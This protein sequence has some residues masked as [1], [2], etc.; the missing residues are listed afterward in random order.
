MPPARSGLP[1]LRTARAGSRTRTH[2]YKDT[3]EDGER[4]APALGSAPAPVRADLAEPVVQ[5]RRVTKLSATKAAHG[6]KVDSVVGE[7]TAPETSEKP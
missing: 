6:G 2:P 1:A 5:P 3:S 7:S 4:K